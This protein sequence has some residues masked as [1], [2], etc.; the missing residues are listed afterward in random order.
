MAIRGWKELK[1]NIDQF[2]KEADRNM[3]TALKAAGL[4]IQ[5]DAKK[6]AP[7]LTGNLKRSIH[8]EEVSKNEVR[9]GTNVEYAIHQE[10]GTKKMAA[11]PY[12]RPALDENRDKILAKF[13]QVIEV[14]TKK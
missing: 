7:Y 14:L 5:N 11:R 6:R 12:L 2:E 13:K 9:V 1:R 8:T 3:I 10:Y 4:I